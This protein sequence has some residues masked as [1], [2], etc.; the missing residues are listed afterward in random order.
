MIQ[1]HYIYRVLYFYY[2]YISSDQQALD[3]GGWGP[4]HQGITRQT[5]LGDQDETSEAK[6]ENLVK[7]TFLRIKGN[8]VKS[9][10]RVRLF[11]TQWTVAYQAPLSMGFSRQYYQSGLPFPSPGDL[12]HPGIEPGSPALKVD[13]LPSESPEKTETHT[14]FIIKRIFYGCDLDNNHQQITGLAL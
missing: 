2:N 5:D 8:E 9:L 6:V 7:R 12:P 14:P 11:A 10:S 3:L 13:S 4:L 1:V